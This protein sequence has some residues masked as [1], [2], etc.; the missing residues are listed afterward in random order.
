M[1]A[2]WLISYR[3]HGQQRQVAFGHNAIAD[4]RAIDPDAAVREIPLSTIEP[5]IGLANAFV[6]NIDEWDGEPAPGQ[7]WH[8]EYQVAQQQLQA[9]GE[10]R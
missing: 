2:I 6:S 1:S 8:H 3:T 5:L 4:Y 7:R 10:A 9:L